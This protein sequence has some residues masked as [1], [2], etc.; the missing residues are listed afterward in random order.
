MHDK[1]RMT[2]ELV[3]NIERNSCRVLQA[4]SR[5]L[6]TVENTK[7]TET[8]SQCTQNFRNF[9]KFNVTP[10]THLLRNCFV[11]FLTPLWNA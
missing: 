9:P 10:W 5:Q 4:Y 3:L 6:R 8:Y 1:F 2:P 7:T 11:A